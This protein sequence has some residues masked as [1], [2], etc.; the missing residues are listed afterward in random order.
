MFDR[1]LFVSVHCAYVCTY[2]HTMATSKQQYSGKVTSVG[3]SRGVRLD[4]AFF[5][6]HPE[7]DGEVRVTV[8]S[9][10]QALL[11]TKPSLV[12]KA[13]S[14]DKDDPVMTTF[15]KFLEQEMINR[16]DFIV[17]ADEVQLRR[18]G[19]LVKGVVPSR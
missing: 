7:F 6:A 17:P 13:A 12:K 18:I 15:L 19:K 3:N 2:I 14:Q 5:R 8:L 4:A 1:Y 9:E 10:G 11:S 16:P